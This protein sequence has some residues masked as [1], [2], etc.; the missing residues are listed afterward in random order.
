MIYK[1]AK[2]KATPGGQRK[3]NPSPLHTVAV[4]ATTALGVG[5]AAE[6]MLPNPIDA[7]EG[8][9]VDDLER[10]WGTGANQ[11]WFSNLPSAAQLMGLVFSETP[12]AIQTLDPPSQPFFTPET[13]DVGVKIP[14]DARIVCAGST[15]V[16]FEPSERLTLFGPGLSNTV[17]SQPPVRSVSH[18]IVPPKAYVPPPPPPSGGPPGGSARPDNACRNT[19]IA[20]LAVGAIGLL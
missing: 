11:S 6:Q 4:A 12:G 16:P 3:S 10:E 15:C 2:F 9:E 1:G 18:V 7:R 14:Q 13:S 19:V 17:P 8:P 20:A 5:R